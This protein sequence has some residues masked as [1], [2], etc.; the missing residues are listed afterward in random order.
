MRDVVTAF[1][2]EELYYG[3]ALLETMWAIKTLADAGLRTDKIPQIDFEFNMDGCM[4]VLYHYLA[5]ESYDPTRLENEGNEEDEEDFDEY[6]PV[7]L[8]CPE[9][10]AQ[11]ILEAV[12]ETVGGS[13][14]DAFWKDGWVKIVFY[15][16]YLPD[17][18]IMDA[19]DFV[20]KSLEILDERG[21]TLIG[22]DPEN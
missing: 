13:V 21:G 22:D 16:G 17:P 10:K 15:P 20:I 3:R 8:A 2:Y 7:W 11:E 4:T 6:A 18:S 1:Q 14:V 9:E 5:V 12:A 19:T